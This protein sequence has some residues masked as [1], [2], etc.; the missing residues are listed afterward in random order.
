MMGNYRKGKI[1]IGQKPVN[2]VCL[3]S[4]RFSRGSYRE[5]EYTVHSAVVIRMTLLGIARG[6]KASER[7]GG[8]ESA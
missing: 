8:E 6:S 7:E 3:S 2:I 1:E 5:T 4:K